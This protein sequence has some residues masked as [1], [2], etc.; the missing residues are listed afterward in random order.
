MEETL[1]LGITGV[2]EVPNGDIYVTDPAV[3]ALLKEKLAELDYEISA[4]ALNTKTARRSCRSQAWVAKLQSPKDKQKNKRPYPHSALETI[5]IREAW[6]WFPLCRS[7]ELAEEIISA[8]GMIADCSYY[9]QDGQREFEDFHLKRMRIFV[10][11][12][13]SVSIEEWDGMIKDA[14]LSGPGMV[15][16]IMAFCQNISVSEMVVDDAPNVANLLLGFPKIMKGKPRTDAEIA[17][18]SLAAADHDIRQDF[19]ETLGARG[20]S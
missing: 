19:M 2:I 17:A 1:N 15:K 20:L 13:T 9:H 5:I 12:L 8:A 10:Q 7:K 11:G 16:A 4:C 6:T 14:P 3:M 18:M